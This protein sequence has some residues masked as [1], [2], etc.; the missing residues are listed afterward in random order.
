MKKSLNSLGQRIKKIRKAKNITQVELAVETGLS[1]S[2][3]ASIEQ[4]V[5]MPSLKTLNKIAKS[6]NI[7][8]N[9][10]L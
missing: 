4:S 8:P 1:P 2:Y 6:L 3:I 5:R 7:K 10:L 9:E